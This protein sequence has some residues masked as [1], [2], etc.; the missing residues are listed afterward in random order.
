[1]FDGVVIITKSFSHSYMGGRY[2]SLVD[3][4][5]VQLQN[6]TIF[7]PITAIINHLI[8]M[9]FLLHFLVLKNQLKWDII[10]HNI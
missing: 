3:L 7:H 2:I 10:F 1:M 5:L 6:S 4:K 8:W 9:K